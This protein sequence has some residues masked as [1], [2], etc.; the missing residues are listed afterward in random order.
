MSAFDSCESDYGQT[1]L[2]SETLFTEVGGTVLSPG[3]IWGEN[4]RGMVGLLTKLVQKTPILPIIGSGNDVLYLVHEDDL[5][6]LVM[7]SLTLPIFPR[8]PYITVAAKEA[9]TFRHILKTFAIREKKSPLIVPIP[10]PIVFFSLKTLEM[11]SINLPIRSDSVIGLVKSN[12]NV[13]FQEKVLQEVGF[14]G[15][16]SFLV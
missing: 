1:K 13:V 14:K 9:V 2:A 16:R 7:M 3:L 8:A 12:S 15:F 6:D 5:T 11:L 4:P 10:W